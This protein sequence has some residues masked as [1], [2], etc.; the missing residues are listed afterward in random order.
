MT[1]VLMLKHL[2]THA[3]AT[4]LLAAAAGKSKSEIRQL[5]ADRQP[6]LDV[7]ASVRAL[8]VPRDVS[9]SSGFVV[10]ERQDT[11]RPKIEPLAPQKFRASSP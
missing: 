2:L 4:E 5:M 6:R 3:T 8:P 7:P 9:E 11:P 1:T 10:P